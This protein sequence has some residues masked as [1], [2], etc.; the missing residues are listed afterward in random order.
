MTSSTRSAAATAQREQRRPSSSSPG[1][2]TDTS[3]TFQYNLST[4]IILTC[5]LTCLKYLLVTSSPAQLYRS[6]DFD[7]HRNWLAIARHLPLSQWYHDD[8]GGTTVHTL[9]YPPTF[10]YFEYLLSNNPVTNTLLSRGVLDGRCLEL[11]GDDDNAPSEACVKFQRMTVLLSDVVLYAAAWVASRA[12]Y[13]N[14]NPNNNDI[15]RAFVAAALI[16]TN[17]GLLLLDHVH[18]QY[19][20]MLLGILLLSIGCLARGASASASASACASAT[21]FKWDLLGAFLY[22]FLLGMKHLYLL[23][24]PLYFAYLLRHCCFVVRA[25]T[26]KYEKNK[27]NAKAEPKPPTFSFGRFLALAAV[28]GTTLVLPY[29]PILLATESGQRLD[30]LLQ[31]LRRL[32]PYQRGLVHSYWAA[33]CWAVY[34][35]ADK[36][37]RFVLGR[38]GLASIHLPDVPPSVCSVLL[39]IA[40][41]P[42]MIHAWKAA[43][44]TLRG[45]FSDDQAASFFVHA[46]VCSAFSGFML[47]YHCHEKA[48]MTCIVPL[49]LLATQSKRNAQLFLRAS[50]LGHFGILPL[51]Y[52]PTELGLKT[53]AYVTYM[54]LSVWV[55]K[56]TCNDESG[57]A[58]SSK[59]LT[60]RWDRIGLLVL[61]FV[62]VFMEV[63]HPLFLSNVE[64]FAFLPLLMTSISCAAG[65]IACWAISLMHMRDAI[66]CGVELNKKED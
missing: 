16:V 1:A 17:P 6:T 46:V 36:C 49:T 5:I 53:L 37:I 35:F 56:M 22:A 2:A 55:L 64:R 66:A 19:N 58:N 3:A 48:I 59:K 8:V 38:V 29:M 34:M 62:Y 11:L 41:L 20:G 10:A 52:R 47:A 27:P 63:L 45:K 7:V 33:N 13:P 43:T 57:S 54:A 30:Q 9:D 21:A 4:Y 31:I 50:S 51:L 61:L 42:A 44:N 24:G 14:P 15:P 26:T 18:F 60:N 12:I 28:T 39:L 40:L 25:T 23:L 32:F 65:L